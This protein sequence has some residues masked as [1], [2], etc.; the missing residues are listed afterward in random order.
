[1]EKR[2]SQVMAHV[3]HSDHGAKWPK[4]TRSHGTIRFIAA[5]GKLQW[6]A[7]IYKKLLPV[8]LDTQ[9]NRKMVGLPRQGGSFNLKLLQHQSQLRQEATERSQLEPIQA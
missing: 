9:S 4:L 2:T 1:M 6:M 7:A 3:F 5:V 8:E